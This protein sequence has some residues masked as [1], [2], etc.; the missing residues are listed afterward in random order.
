MVAPGQEKF[1]ELP[2][3][4]LDAQLD[5]LCHK[6]LQHLIK[7]EVTVQTSLV[8][9]SSSLPDSSFGG[10][11]HDFSVQDKKLSQCKYFLYF[12]WYQPV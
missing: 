2:K 6:S 12:A 11:T 5:M 8:P 4:I 1:P 10:Q 9:P 3:G 7:A